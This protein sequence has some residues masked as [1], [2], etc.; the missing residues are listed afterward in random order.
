MA[1]PN[2]GLPAPSPHHREGG[3]IPG[4]SPEDIA[5][6]LQGYHAAPCGPMGAMGAQVGGPRAAMTRFVA[7]KHA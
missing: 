7:D 3:D 5:G 2:Q 1:R 4:I 6:I